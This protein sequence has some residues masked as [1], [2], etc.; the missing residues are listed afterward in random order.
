MV[1][2][3][4]ININTTRFLEF[5]NLDL[6]NIGHYIRNGRRAKTSNAVLYRHGQYVG[7]VSGNH[8]GGSTTWGAYVKDQAGEIVF[9][10]E[11]VTEDQYLNLRRQLLEESKKSIYDDA[12]KAV[13]LVLH[14][15]MY[16]DINHVFRRR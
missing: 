9:Q 7:S 14:S 13:F 11:E 10:R 6:T 8:Y 5:Y 1:K 4:S 12:T 3:L 2:P 16:T 15:C